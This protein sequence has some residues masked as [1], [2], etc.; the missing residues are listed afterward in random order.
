MTFGGEA[1][2]GGAVFAF[3][4]RTV[5]EHLQQII[6]SQRGVLRPEQATLFIARAE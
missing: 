3:L 5:T 4:K 1:G 6:A 2:F